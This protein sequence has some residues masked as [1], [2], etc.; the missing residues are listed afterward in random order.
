MTCIF[1]AIV[2]IRQRIDFILMNL[3]FVMSVVTSVVGRG[4]Y[5]GDARE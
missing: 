1:I 3:V 4:V 5:S 2:V